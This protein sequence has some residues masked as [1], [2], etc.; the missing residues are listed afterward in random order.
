MDSNNRTPLDYYLL[1]RIDIASAMLRIAEDNGPALDGYRF[2]TLD[3]LYEFLRPV[4]ME[5]AA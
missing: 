5:G 4:S 1:P 2:D 3:V